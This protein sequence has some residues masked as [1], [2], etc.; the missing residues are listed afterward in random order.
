MFDNLE[1]FIGY[2][3]DAIIYLP[4]GYIFL[5]IYSHIT[6]NDFGASFQDNFLKSIVTGYVLNKLYLL[7]TFSSGEESKASVAVFLFSAVL[8]YILAQITM[9]RRFRCLLSILG[10]S[11]HTEHNIW[12]SIS[13]KEH[14]LWAT[15]YFRENNV[16]YQGEVACFED[17]STTPQIVLARYR[18]YSIVNGRIDPKNGLI[19]D[20]SSVFEKRVLLNTALA[21]SV[22]LTYDKRSEVVK[23]IKRVWRKNKSA[24]RNKNK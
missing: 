15:V 5:L 14:P 10:I 21:D 9:S 22:E 18:K 16:C 17:T 24:S 12:S 13:D 6:P 19:E 1:V 7:I 2:L 11:R 8:A 3:N 20:N 4:S 23:T